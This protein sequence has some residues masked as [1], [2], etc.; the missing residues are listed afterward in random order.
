M[1]LSKSVPLAIATIINAVHSTDILL[2]DFSN[3]QHSW[4]QMNDPVMGG[5]STGSFYLDNG[6]GV[7]NGKVA[8][9]PFLQGPG[10]IKAETEAGEAWP[11]IS[12]CTSMKLTARGLTDYDG[13]RISFGKNKPPGGF[14]FIYGYKADFFLP[15]VSTSSEFVDIVIPF[16]SFSYDW[17]PATGDQITTCSEDESNC[18]DID[19]LKDLY[20][21]A[22]WGEGVKGDVH[23]EI[24]SISATGC[25]DI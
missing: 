18:P 24:Q 9:V 12:S 13:Y 25:T 2:E 19:T 15:Q 22:I 20:S 3:P 8:I 6:I 5:K 7:M 14:M 10:F 4:V 1:F 21:I 11:D 16:T 23:L 17:D